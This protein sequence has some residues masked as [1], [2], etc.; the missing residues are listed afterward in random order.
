MFLRDVRFV[1][2]FLVMI[3]LQAE[4]T[5]IHVLIKRGNK[6]AQDSACASYERILNQL[7][8]KFAR[9]AKN[10]SYKK[11]HDIKPL[12]GV[13]LSIMRDERVM[14]QRRRKRLSS[15]QVTHVKWDKKRLS[16]VLT[17]SYKI[18][19]FEIWCFQ[20]R[21]NHRSHENKQWSNSYVGLTLS[22]DT[23]F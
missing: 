18:K 14:S 22:C 13:H 10:N 6:F 20:F 23:Y 17:R 15:I 12:D 21:S 7:R 5:F 2:L 4:P 11:N 19:N 3:L 8:V 16:V 1:N 9:H